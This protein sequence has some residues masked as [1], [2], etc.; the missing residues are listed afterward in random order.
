[1][2][3]R[4]NSTGKLIDGC[5]GEFAVNLIFVVEKRILVIVI[6]CEFEIAQDGFL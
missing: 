3:G 2:G 1:M 4:N 5:V 6:V